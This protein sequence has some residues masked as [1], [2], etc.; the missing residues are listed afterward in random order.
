MTFNE[1]LQLIEKDPELTGGGAC[2]AGD[3]VLAMVRQ[4]H[5]NSLRIRE[6]EQWAR[7]TDVK[8]QIERN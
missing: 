4:I 6:L 5:D 1:A 7:E 8:L 2:M 3:V